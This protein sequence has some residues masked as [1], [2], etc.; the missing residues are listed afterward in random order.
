MIFFK[1]Y[2]D[3]LG[4]LK[5]T[6]AVPL[7]HPG[8]FWSW[9]LRWAQGHSHMLGFW[10]GRLEH[11]TRVLV[12]QTWVSCICMNLGQLDPV[13][14][15]MHVLG[16]QIDRQT[17]GQHVTKLK[18]QDGKPICSQA[19]GLWIDQETGYVVGRTRDQ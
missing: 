8:F 12:D 11:Q 2:L 1:I 15:P 10:V 14:E 17:L 6:L 13:W 3:S 16:S 9:E 5:H 18:V 4:Y 19:Q 7:H